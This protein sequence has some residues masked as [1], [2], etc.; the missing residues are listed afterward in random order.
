MRVCAKRRAHYA[1]VV[2][3]VQNCFLVHYAQ[4]KSRRDFETCNLFWDVLSVFGN[5]I[6]EPHGNLTR[7]ITQIAVVP[8]ER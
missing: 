1:C 6:G 4:E 8:N 7:R 2:S 3:R 5:L